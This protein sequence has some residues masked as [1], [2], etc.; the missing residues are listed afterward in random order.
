MIPFIWIS[1]VFGPWVELAGWL[2]LAI[3]L[4]FDIPVNW[5]IFFQMWM[6]VLI[7]HYSYMIALLLFV[8]FKLNQYKWDKLYR[9]IPIILMEVFTYHFINLYWLVKSH[10]RQYRGASVSWNKFKRR[11]FNNIK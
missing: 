2:Q 8:K 6:I 7:L 5:G 1:E 3:L 4:Y 11:G 9:C 10:L